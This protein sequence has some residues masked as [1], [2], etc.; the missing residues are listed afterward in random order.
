M[1]VIK[2]RILMASAVSLLVL[3]ACNSDQQA[4]SAAP[5]VKEAVVAT[6]NGVAISKSRVDMIANQNAGAGQPDS[7]D[8]RKSIV[9]QLIMQTLVVGEAVKKGMDKS[10]EVSE[11]I[12]LSRQSILADAYI[13]DFIKSNLVSD[14]TLKSEYERFKDSIGNEYKARHILVEK[15]AE[16][17]D[18]IAKLQKDPGSF[19][20]LAQEK[21][22]DTATKAKGGD[23][24]WF[25]PRRMAPEFGA[26]VK[27]LEK[28]KFTDEPVVTS[29]GYHV[30]LQ[31]D[32]RPL[33]APPL[34]RIKAGLTQQ[35][36][37]QSLM[38][39][40][41]DLKAKAKIEITKTPEAEAKPET[42]KTPAA[43]AK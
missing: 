36:Q 12:E 29:F 39:H 27:L 30:I 43:P 4:K 35:I 13:Q 5:A 40:L 42:A 26:A 7:P 8:V 28:G 23:L 37:Q 21:S 33:E 2:P 6:V 31:E 15:E 17:K 18:I 32:S 1:I 11:Q 24:G 38:K 25:D 3:S 16:A 10:T 34:D 20:K 9:D 19:A 14:D 22:K 41:D